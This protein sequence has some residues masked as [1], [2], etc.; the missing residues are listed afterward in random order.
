MRCT[1]SLAMLFA[2]AFSGCGGDEFVAA[3][4]PGGTGGAPGDA[5]SETDGSGGTAGSGGSDSGGSGGSGE[6][7]TV[8]DCPATIDECTLSV[9]C[10][11]GKCEP[12]YATEGRIAT[13]QTVG[14]CAINVC[15][16]EGNIVTTA[17]N[18]D[19]PSDGKPCTEDSCD[20]GVPVHTNAPPGTSCGGTMTCDDGGNC[21]GCATNDDCDDGTGCRVWTCDNGQCD[22]TAATDGTDCGLCKACN[23]GVCGNVPSG[24]EEDKD[25]DNEPPCGTD[26][27]C[28]GGGGCRYYS[29]GA[30]CG[31]QP[32]CSGVAAIP[33]DSCN[34]SGQ[35]VD[36]APIDCTP[37]AC[38]GGACRTECDVSQDCAPGFECNT[39]KNC[40]DC[41]LC[42]DWL[43]NPAVQPAQF[44]KGDTS[45]LI[46][47]V[48]GCGCGASGGGCLS[49]CGGN[50]NLCST[51]PAPASD[52]C[53]DC[54]EASCPTHWQ[55]C[56]A[57]IPG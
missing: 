19:A 53:R 28:N 17:D 2:L 42:G 46:A 30:P 56:A 1:V 21:L 5:S 4:T 55:S 52:P 33:A 54:L 50:N 36:E 39:L 11:E 43:L 37:Y 29:A 14:D 7:Q 23:G 6:C 13:A 41:E 26:G 18:E 8:S 22:S 40:V 15:D 31:N 34:G 3:E 45:N 12:E 38:N 25:C 49:Q 48:L 10:H 27:T 44:C 35:C 32:A 47:A 24:V 16:G 57:D 9:A 20:G 51:L